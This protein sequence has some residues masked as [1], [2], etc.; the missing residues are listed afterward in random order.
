MRTGIFAIFCISL[1]MTGMNV[2]LAQEN[3]T[4]LTYYRITDEIKYSSVNLSKLKWVYE[5]E[6]YSTEL[7]FR[8]NQAAPAG[9][10]FW[11]Y[12]AYKIGQAES[13]SWGIYN[14]N[15]DIICKN[16]YLYNDKEEGWRYIV[17]DQNNLTQQIVPGDYKLRFYLEKQPAEELLY[18]SVGYSTKAFLDNVKSNLEENNSKTSDA[19]TNTSS[20][21]SD[22]KTNT[23]ST[24]ST[25]SN[26]DKSEPSDR[27]N[28]VTMKALSM[29]PDFT[30][31]TDPKEQ[32][33]KGDEYYRHRYYRFAAEL[34]MKCMVED[35]DC[36]YKFLE[37]I[38]VKDNYSNIFDEKIYPELLEKVFTVLSF[39]AKENDSV[40]Q[41]Y[42]GNM[43]DEGKGKPKDLSEAVKWYR[44]S[45]EQGHTKAQYCLGVMY[46]YGH[47][48]LKD[49]AEAVRW[50]RKSADQGHMSAQNRLGYS[51]ETGEGVS[52]DYVEAL[53]WYRKAVDQGSAVAH[54]NV[55]EIYKKGGYGV[56][57]NDSEAYK[58]KEKAKKMGFD[59]SYFVFWRS[60]VD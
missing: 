53:K 58:W 60:I 32:K 48:I 36:L 23:S 4:K 43:Y 37:I 33:E 26:D 19:K 6:Q 16:F 14:V 46:Y 3:T 28:W 30:D 29:N 15:N 13:L 25:V 11:L 51:Y 42:L 45:A 56:K 41:Y 21:T 57:K 50:Y 17:Q 9:E 39:L 55:G 10:L 20:T 49:Y 38:M 1:L 8:V 54:N 5:N 24:T 31:I 12:V 7:P 59:S 44:K 34:Y 35:K 40:A 2:T 27:K 18:L 52:K 22:A 47:G